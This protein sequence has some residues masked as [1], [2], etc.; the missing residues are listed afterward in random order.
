MCRHLEQQAYGGNH[1]R[2]YKLPIIA[3][4][5]GHKADST[6][7]T[8]FC[9]IG[10]LILGLCVNSAV[11]AETSDWTGNGDGQSWAD[12][13]NWTNGVPNSNSDRANLYTPATSV[14][15]MG[16]SIFGNRVRLNQLWFDLSDDLTLTNSIPGGILELY[17]ADSGVPNNLVADSPTSSE[18]RHTLTIEND[19]AIFGGLTWINANPTG[20]KTRIV[21]DITSGNTS[22]FTIL[23]LT[24]RNVDVPGAA[25]EIQGNISDGNGDLVRV[26]TGWV[27]DGAHRNVVRLTGDNTF[28]GGINVFTNTLEFDSVG[29]TG[30]ASALGVGNATN[31]AADQIDIGAGSHTGTL[32]YIGTEPLGHATNRDVNLFGTTGGARLEANGVGPL[33]FDGD[34]LANNGN[35]KTLTLAG[36]N[37]GSINGT[38]NDLSGGSV[39]VRKEGTGKWTL[40]G[41]N[42]YAGSTVVAGGEL[43]V[44]GRLGT[45][46]YSADLLDVSST[47]TIHGANV[48]VTDLDQTPTSTLNFRSGLLELTNNA[49][50][51]PGGTSTQAGSIDIG[52]AG[53]GQ[54]ILSGGTQRFETVTLNG[55]DDRLDFRGGTYRFADLDNSTG[56]TIATEGNASLITIDGQFT[57][58]IPSGSQTFTAPIA[59]GGGLTKQGDG[60][61]RLTAEH[62]YNGL[63]HV[64][65]GTLEL[66]PTANLANDSPVR[67][68]ALATLDMSRVSNGDEFGPLTGEG[69]L[70]NGVGSDVAIDTASGSADFAG[71]IRGGGRVIKRGLG[72]QSLS[73][74]STY[75]GPTVL[76]SGSGTLRI[77]EGGSLVGTA[78]VFVNSELLMDGGRIESKGDINLSS[79][80]AKL[81]MRGGTLKATQIGRPWREQFIT[82]F[83]FDWTGG[84]VHLTSP[85]HL[86]RAEGVREDAPFTSTL[87]LEAN[88][89]LVVDENLDLVD[90]GELNIVGGSVAAKDLV[91][92]ANAKV[93]FQSGRLRV[94]SDQ[95]L[96]A[97]RLETL[98]LQTPIHAGRTF[99][100][101]GQATLTSRLTLTS[102]GTFSAGSLI[103]PENLVLAG[104][105][106]NVTAGDLGIR[107]GRTV[108]ATSGTEINVSGT[109]ENSGNLNLIGTTATFA[110]NS[111]NNSEI[112]AINSTLRFDDGLVNQGDLNLINSEVLG[113]LS[114]LQSVTVAGAA[115]F[116]GPVASRGDFLGDGTLH[117]HDG[118]SVDNSPAEVVF[119]GDVVFEETNTLELDLGGIA[120]GAFDQ[121][122]VGGE[123]TL[124]GLLRIGLLDGFVPEASDTFT[125]L[126][127]DVLNGA[128]ENVAPGGRLAISG[129]QGTFL[130]DYGST[131]SFNVDS[132]VLS[133][134]QLLDSLFGDFNSNGQLD[135]IDIDLLSVAVGSD[136]LTFDLTADGAVTEADRAFWVETLKSTRFGDADLNGEVEFADFLTLSAAF[137]QAGG[138]AEGDF[139]GDREVGFGDFLLL[140][141][142][143]GQ[144]NPQ[145]ISV[146][147]PSMG[148]LLGL[149]LFGLAMVRR[150]R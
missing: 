36:T 78:S 84:T 129:G 99:E 96:T 35:T 31:P 119:E 140:S 7:A 97:D 20:H 142:N 15:D 9:W 112:N 42:L 68:D 102:G 55:P 126:D 63:T 137:G 139:D 131:S 59:G 17:G 52:V 74:P 62:T 46:N 94:N 117:F 114:N 148:K 21:G 79:S 145:A 101:G 56:G 72:T 2:H 26:D 73:G 88:K 12:P 27:N 93:N 141:S 50:D 143:F 69:V 6:R 33:A 108:D 51:G 95:D 90:Q 89:T 125:V 111:I 8:I 132:L 32:R 66:A 149:S 121:L 77:A 115:Q 81:S 47:F 22:G 76:E 103:H 71:S 87:S 37:L 23:Q 58:N 30:V 24:G 133:D 135:G 60:I 18:A 64:Q 146:P 100:V 120:D 92:H 98:D 38:I 104:G 57:Q 28:S 150:R 116:A 4:N 106:L 10:W 86:G 83:D 34:V 41:D 19:I 138:W 110:A 147:E 91:L 80:D 11:Q 124:G 16:P 107:V 39:N 65:A 85:T 123:A 113:P 1:R 109:L 45:D 144:S 134:F 5:T 105:Q 122:L 118:F 70:L 29:N 40:T 136:D 128:F 82:T 43:E 130:V 3:T 67:I 13:D 44:T 25:I 61:L 54:L 49:V 48:K 75:T 53:T 127:A 14:I